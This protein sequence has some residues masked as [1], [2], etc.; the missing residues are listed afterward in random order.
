MMSRSQNKGS[1][2]RWVQE[3]RDIFLAAG[4]LI[5][6]FVLPRYSRTS[7]GGGSLPA[8]LLQPCTPIH[9]DVYMPS[10]HSTGVIY[11]AG[12]PTREGYG[13]FF[14]HYKGSIIIAQY[15]KK[16]LIIQQDDVQSEHG[17]YISQQVNAVHHRGRQDI[18]GNYSEGAC[19]MP[20]QYQ[21]EGITEPDLLALMCLKM[22]PKRFNDPADMF[23]VL[24]DDMGLIRAKLG[25]LEVFEAR[26]GKCT[27]I[28]SFG[29]KGKFE[30][31]NDCAQPWVSYTLHGMFR[32]RGY[33]A[34]ALDS[35]CLSVGV[36]V[37]WGDVATDDARNLGGRN[38]RLKEILF[39]IE[40][41]QASGRCLRWHVFA[42]NATAQLL[43]QFPVKHTYVD[44]GDDLQD[45]FTYS[46]MDLYVQGVSSFAV[47]ATLASRGK[48][49]ITSQPEHPKYNSNF[50]D[51]NHIYHFADRSYVEAVKNLRQK[52]GEQVGSPF[53]PAVLGQ[54]GGYVLR[55]VP[56]AAD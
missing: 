35:I 8:S 41:L 17:Y 20:Q 6:Y 30:K 40:Q 22:S 54:Q 19:E 25:A 31:F 50:R 52:H 29:R 42:K 45:M 7:V 53:A 39:V 23:K 9:D 33:K 18:T 36:H 37:R 34:L 12:N 16:T 21:A 4:F 48:L 27:E 56:V 28:H 11:R 44:T 24:G 46:Q 26:Y 2:L 14:Q 13:S 15:L 47:V 51:V 5:V 55:V 1:V 38:M 3:H 10:E 49:I 32:D 43:A